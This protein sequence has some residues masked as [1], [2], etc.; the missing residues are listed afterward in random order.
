MRALADWSSLGAVEAVGIDEV[1]VHIGFFRGGNLREE[2]ADPSGVLERVPAA[3][4]ADDKANIIVGRPM[5]N[6]SSRL[7]V[8]MQVVIRRGIGLSPGSA[9]RTSLETGAWKLSLMRRS[10]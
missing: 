1:S 8:T 2:L 5:M 3:T 9:L 4:F 7:W 10:I 6:W